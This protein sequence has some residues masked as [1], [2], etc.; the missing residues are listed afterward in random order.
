VTEGG[1]NASHSGGVGLSL[2]NVLVSGCLG[3]RGLLGASV[4]ETMGGSSDNDATGG[5]SCGVILGKGGIS[6]G[7]GIR[8]SEEGTVL[9]TG[10]NGMLSVCWVIGPD[11]GNDG[12]RGMLTGLGI[13]SIGIS[14]SYCS[15]DEYSRRCDPQGTRGSGGDTVQDGSTGGW[16]G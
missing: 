14:G 4:I 3:N 10:G 15:M 13:S 12:G 2:D 8:S 7:R 9:L 11:I 1:W 16:L 5:D 6:H